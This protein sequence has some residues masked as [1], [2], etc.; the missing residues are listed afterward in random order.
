MKIRVVSVCYNEE[1]MLPFYLRHYSQFADEIFVYDDASTDK[2]AEMICGCKKAY[3]LPWPY[4]PGLNDEAM[5]DLWYKSMKQARD[6]GIDWIIFPDIDEFVWSRDIVSVLKA[7]DAMGYEVLI[8]QGWNMIGSG[9]GIPSDDGRQIW[10]QY[11]MGVYQGVYSKPVI[12]KPSS[13]IKWALG[14]HNAVNEPRNIC[15]NVF[16]LKLLHYRFMGSKYT[17][18]RNLKN[19]SRVAVARNTYFD[20]NVEMH[21]YGSQQYAHE[22]ISLAMNAVEH[23]LFSWYKS[24]T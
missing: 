15:C 8:P 14:R 1:F 22:I 12:V 20:G 21:G 6:D 16:M 17:Q 2:S 18:A 9:D 19:H 3:V 4:P 7:A 13:D 5:M 10:E 23:P 11:Q 24:P